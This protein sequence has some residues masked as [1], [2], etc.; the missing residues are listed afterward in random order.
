MKISLSSALSSAL[1]SVLPLVLAAVLAGAPVLLL[2]DQALTAPYSPVPGGTTWGLG[3]DSRPWRR[4]P[5]RAEKG[6]DKK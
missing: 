2:A 1:S 6:Q 4:A 3:A 5:G